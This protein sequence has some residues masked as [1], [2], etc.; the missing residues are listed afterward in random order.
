MGSDHSIA[1]ILPRSLHLSHV[2]GI[3]NTSCYITPGGWDVGT[4]CT[5]ILGTHTLWVH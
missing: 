2:S 1:S 3:R 4:N 5:N